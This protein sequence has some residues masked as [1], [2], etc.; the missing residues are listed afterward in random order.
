MS[1]AELYDGYKRLL[2]RLYSHRNYRKR[3]MQLI[4][5]K[6][7]Q[8]E[9]KLVASRQDFAILARVL[10][11]CILRASPKRAWLT[12]ALLGET[13]LRR[14][15]ALRDAVTTR[16]DSQA[17][18]RIHARNLPPAGRV[19][20]YVD[21]LTLLPASQTP[22]APLYI[23]SAGASDRGCRGAIVSDYETW[24]ERPRRPR[25]V[26]RLHADAPTEVLSLFAPRLRR[27]TGSSSGR[28]ATRAMPR[29]SS[30]TRS[31]GL[32]L[33]PSVRW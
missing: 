1:S 19:S 8:L 5:N 27:S 7:A 30:R 18:V 28:W 4:L 3:V 22:S 31:S 24:I 17:P 6:G 33:A 11:T 26:E 10:W 23:Q 20:R 21:R 13:L 14:P 25:S 32:L 2:Q 15:R 16:A 29:T 12:V 9:N